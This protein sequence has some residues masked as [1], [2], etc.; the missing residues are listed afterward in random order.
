VLLD[1]HALI[2]WFEDAPQLSQAARR[3]IQNAAPGPFYSPASVYEVE[4]KIAQAKLRP[5]QAAL[6]DL[7]ANQGFI[8][9]AV[10]ARHADLAAR[11]SS[12]HRDPWDRLMAAQAIVEGMTIV[13]RDAKLAA[14][15][16]TVLW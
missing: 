2:W 5:L 8:E 16:A 6:I 1:T 10:S 12:A 4:Y 9:L 14:L 15:G 3:A 13:T 7:A 11:L